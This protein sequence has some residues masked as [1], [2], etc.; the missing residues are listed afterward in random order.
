MTPMTMQQYPPSRR[1]GRL[2]APFLVLCATTL[3]C[4]PDGAF[5]PAVGFDFLAVDPNEVVLL[6]G[7]QEGILVSPRDASGTP[8]EVPAGATVEWESANPTIASVNQRGRF[9]ATVTGHNLGETVLRATFE[10]KTVEVPVTVTDKVACSQ[11][12]E[13]VKLVGETLQSPEFCLM[14]TSNLYVGP[15]DHS[16]ASEVDI[17][18]QPQ[19][20]DYTK[21]TMLGAAYFSEG[22]PALREM[23]ANLGPEYMTLQGSV[24]DPPSADGPVL[25]VWASM[26]EDI[27]HTPDR[28][29]EYSLTLDRDWLPSNNITLRAEFAD[30]WA[31]DSDFVYQLGYTGTNGS[32]GMRALDI[33]NTS[34]VPTPPVPVQTNAE[35]LFKGKTTLWIVPWTGRP[36]GPLLRWTAFGHEG[37]FGFA[38]PF[39]GD[40]FPSPGQPLFSLN[41]YEY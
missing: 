15:I 23:V 34:G 21:L 2:I 25:V 32:W 16:W 40:Y 39:T 24:V 37:D 17:P 8:A 29:V 35:V 20:S 1:P 19:P 22:R 13:L 7:E 30:D 27:P 4:E 36:E 33:S 38:M 26:Q 11:N 31:V 14:S 28:D 10:G 12:M 6:A 18:L 41:G 9:Y 3:G 5:A